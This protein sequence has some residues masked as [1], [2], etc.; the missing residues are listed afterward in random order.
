MKQENRNIAF[1]LNYS[2]GLGAYPYRDNIVGLPT[3]SDLRIS[4]M[5]K[6]ITYDIGPGADGVYF[7][8]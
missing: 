4:I 5:E 8:L 3:W 2:H 1:S 6:G 7:I